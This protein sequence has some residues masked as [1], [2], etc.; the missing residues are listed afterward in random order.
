MANSN[1]VIFIHPD[2]TSP[3]HYAAA[4]FV[5]YGPDGRL[6]WDMMSNA[7]V[8]LGHMEDQLTGTSNAG[9]ITHAF[10][11]KVPAGS[12]G[13]DENGEPVVSLS[14]ERGISIMEEAIAAGKGTAVINSGF[15][16]E[17]GTG[18]FLAEV[19]NR[20]DVTGITAQIVESGVDII[21]GGGEI[22][23]L[24]VG[25]TGRFGQEGVREDGRNLIEEAE[26][27]G[28]TVVYTLEELQALP[29][30]T[31]K[32]LGIFA[33]E[34]TYNDTNEETLAEQGLEPY[35]QPGN[36]NPPTIAQMME[37]AIEILSSNPNGFFIVMEE[38]G[39]D[40]FANNNNAAGTIEATKRA[41]DAIGVA[42]NYVDNVNPN[43]LIIT[44]ADSDAGGLEVRDPIA[45]DEPVG[46]V[47]NNPIRTDGTPNPLDGVDGLGTEP[48][49][50]APAEN[51]NVYPF[52]VGWAGTADVPGS[53]VSKTYGLNADKLPSTLDN[54]EIYRLMYETLFDEVL[55][56]PIPA[57]APT[58]A[59]EATEETGNVIFIHPDGT[60]PSHYA[61]ARFV[62]EGPD[63][64]LNW[65]MMSNAGVYLGHMEDQLTGTSNSGA[66][67]HAFGVK[68]PA[69]SYGLDANGNPVTSASGQQGV[70]I[71]EE[72]IAAGKATAVINS[73]FIAEPGTGAFLA[74]VE[75]RS[76]VTSITAQVVESGTSVILG[77]GEI[78]Y[79]PTGTV[80]R[81]GEEGVREDGRNLIEEAK[82]AG[83]TVVYTLEEL[84]SL[85][86]G[87]E[88]VLGI[89]AAEDTYNDTTEG[90]LFADDL[91][92]YGQPGNENPPTVAQ[93]LE[94][95]L[96]IVSQD[97]DG[98]MVVLEEEGS[99]NFG[100]NN[101]AA[102]TIEATRRA[103]DA[104]GVAMDFVNEQDP[105]TLVITAADSD[106]GGLEVRD[107]L[108]ADEPVG[109]NP[110]NPTVDDRTELIL[111][112]TDGANTFPFTSAPD[113]NGNTYPF[114][115]SWVGTPDF[116][117]SIVSKTYG[118]N[119]DLLPSTLDN[120][121]IYKI[122]YQTLF[123]VDVDA[124]N[125]GG[126]GNG[127]G[128]GN[129]N[130]NGNGNG[131]ETPSA[132]L[133]S[134]ASLAADTFAEGPE[135]G[136]NN[137]EGEPISANDRTGPFEGQPVQGFSGVQFA[138]NSDGSSFWFLS[139]NGFGSKANSS[140]YLLRLYQVKPNF[141]DNSVDIEGF[142]Q[143]SDPDNLIPFD[144]QNEDTEE[145]LLTGSDFDIESFVIA[146]DNT[147]WVGDEFGPYL[148]HF[149]LEGKLLEAPIATPNFFDLNTLNGQTPLVIGH[150]GAS[151]SR[152][153]HTLEAYQLAI[154]QGA[155][156]IE[157]D[158][159]P[160]KDGVLIARHEPDL[161]RVQLDEEGNIV[162]DEEGNPIVTSESTNVAHLE[163]FADRLTVK[164]IDGDR[165][166]GW[167][168]EDFTLEEIKQLKARER[169]PA[170]R[171]GNTE[172]NDQFEVPTFAEVIDLVKRVEAET[173]KTIGIYP[174]T[175]HPTFFAKEGTFLDGTPINIDTSQLLVD[176]L[177][178]NEFTNPDR[179]FIQSFEI[180]N[181]L[182]LQN[183]IM[184]EA[185][186]D[187]PLVQLTGDFT[188]SEGSF[189][190]P[191]D[192]VYNFGEGNSNAD[193][194]VYE[195]F[196]IS[197]GSDTDY[198]DLANP[199]VINYIGEAY[200]EGLGPWKNSFLLR[201]PLEEAVDGNGD[202]VA[203]ITS[204]LTGEVL[205]LIEWAHDAGLQVH[206]YTLRNEENF[207]TLNA[208]GTPQTPE[209]EIEQLIQLGVDGFFTD[210]PET[211]DLVR[212]RVV[213]DEVRSP[214]NPA[215]LAEEA[216]ANLP[217]SRG[218]EGMAISPD[219]NT[220]YPLLEGTVTGDPAGALRIHRFDREA[221]EYEGLVGYYQL[222]DPSH[223]IGD[224]AAVNDNEYLVIERDN[225]Q[226]DEAA[227][228][229]IFK[230]DLSQV[231]ENGFVEK[232]EL[233]NLLS[234]SDP[235]DLNG[236]GS[237]EFTFPFQT[238][239][240]VLVLDENTIL[241]A[242]DNNYP[243]SVG[244]PPAIDNNEIITIELG[245]SLN[246][247]A[248]VG[249]PGLETSPMAAD[250][251]A[252]A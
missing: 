94:A 140:D 108:D 54:T 141:D 151:G 225:L 37:K 252:V 165:V 217:R 178:E 193:P 215:V 120:T 52:A 83:Y 229:S 216:V 183:E 226:A 234:V 62:Q 4:R 88:K 239:E 118:M 224:F 222:E 230:V 44:A 250:M 11:V 192:V 21:L 20:S 5:H 152:P 204:Q 93:M 95:A 155:D 114:G 184:P 203:E 49:V 53:I 67:T 206:P 39:T 231:D 142:V 163:Q 172:F 79:L 186:I 84:Q 2:G 72:A 59:P 98:F 51:G 103:D 194:S 147:I 111:D 23:Y 55:E 212:D 48:F 180:E 29:A 74:E 65:D 200:A 210:F 195:G 125:G 117:G 197:F 240:D 247:A 99:D 35:G 19:E 87:T 89:F 119:A 245:Q 228:K 232:E 164:V 162:L 122:M 32:V 77:G 201:E 219:G 196:P 112:G 76:D 102:G 182:R 100:N 177:V 144:I 66:V 143:L 70:T 223:A 16:A 31:E 128:D 242:N 161:A 47:N 169:I 238:I 34:D 91:P 109:V 132:T 127:N 202:G 213:A 45:A 167:F 208:D 116:P 154:E 150:R 43:T 73:G 135:A 159:V 191:Y 190:A 90:N 113:A 9:A 69:G 139:D 24:P 42:M 86:E 176:T 227:F 220:L 249:L 10:G 115:V 30:D 75:N 110:A 153:E 50:S 205:P 221:K 7:G 14:G 82:A 233:V 33:A 124:D 126:N 149:D 209:Q 104:I 15:I 57:P 237:T 207:L 134:F 27:A 133:T 156:F 3:S 198:G 78:H 38:E 137:G 129:G 121:E 181:L 145:R 28:Y 101:N 170:T 25:T 80:G 26:A 166:G 12:Y 168:A 244:R 18:A 46:T 235:D 171:P 1:S 105:N 174:E 6:N 148:L 214:D 138:P 107:P 199:E 22:H 248:G 130:G 97:P 60:S 17:P 179:I 160:T 131:G 56:S 106:A 36:E 61:A 251:G 63:G 71:L 175:K 173:G 96:G 68:A 218:F 241:V 146:P 188:N 157:P 40:N 187:I 185:G 58:P 85:P 158:L 189:S 136:S 211:G 123:G 236:D 246:L 92:F 81:F 8:Y 243:F 64:R 41:D 13:L